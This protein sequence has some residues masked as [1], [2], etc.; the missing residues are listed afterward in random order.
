MVLETD[1]PALHPIKQ[2][3][4]SAAATA[5]IAVASSAAPSSSPACCTPEL[6]SPS[7]LY[8]AL[9]TLHELYLQASRIRQE[10]EQAAAVKKLAAAQR[11]GGRAQAKPVAGKI[12]AVSIDA[13]ASP[14]SA[15]PAQLSLVDL[16]RLLLRNSS[17]LFARCLVVR[18]IMMS[19]SSFVSL[20]SVTRGASL[21]VSLHPPR[22]CFCSLIA[23][24]KKKKSSASVATAAAAPAATAAHND[25]AAPA[26]AAAASMSSASAAAPAAAPIAQPW[27]SNYEAMKLWPIQQDTSLFKATD[28]LADKVNQSVEAAPLAAASASASASAAS[29]AAA[30]AAPVARFQ[31]GIYNSKADDAGRRAIAHGHIAAGQ[32]TD[33]ARREDSE[34]V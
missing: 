12:E 10:S 8:V 1:S 32:R 6:N 20:V 24:G 7:N 3:P 5:V 17:L 21:S 25:A 33:G 15:V 19:F 26:P 13:A 9:L 22:C 2:P 11:A 31:F 14:A 30:G 18:W 27:A 34:R 16:A 29:S 28:S 23:M 4:P